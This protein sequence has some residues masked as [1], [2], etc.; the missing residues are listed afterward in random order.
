MKF[1]FSSSGNAETGNARIATPNTRISTTAQTNSGITA[2]ESPPT[3]NTRSTFLPLFIAAAMPPKML[4]GAIKINATIANC[5]DLP[6][7]GPKISPTGCSYCNEVPRSPV[8]TPPIHRPYCTT[9]GLSKPFS[10]FQISK[11]STVA[12]LPR[13]CLAISPG[14]IEVIKKMITETMTRVKSDSPTRL[15]MN[16]S[17]EIS[18]LATTEQHLLTCR[19]NKKRPT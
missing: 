3:V 17:I 18:S 1:G 10:L 12:S 16:L 9:S 11:A 7:A 13:V 6:A 2:A 19:T 8:T 15:T 5:A 14:K 4:M